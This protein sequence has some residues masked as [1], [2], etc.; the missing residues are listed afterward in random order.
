MDNNIIPF[1][2]QFPKPS[3]NK[4]QYYNHGDV[5]ATQQEIEKLIWG[6]AKKED[7]IE[8][9]IIKHGKLLNFT[10]QTPATQ[11]YIEH[12]LFGLLCS[13]IFED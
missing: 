6:V 11:P 3:F 2:P 13:V 8:R 7:E 9:F 4:W 12:T 10:D 5:I 1:E